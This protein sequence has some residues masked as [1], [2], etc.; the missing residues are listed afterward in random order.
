M[1]RNEFDVLTGHDLLSLS[2]KLGRKGKRR[3]DLLAGGGR[4]VTT[5]DGNGSR[6]ILGIGDRD[7]C[8]RP[9]GRPTGN[10]LTILC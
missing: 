10:P 6:F 7:P 8:A 4:E 3:R 2:I 9:L 5:Q 1:A